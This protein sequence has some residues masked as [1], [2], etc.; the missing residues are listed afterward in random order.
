[1]P[2]IATEIEQSGAIKRGE[3][4]LSDGTMTD[5]YVD[6]YVFETR[7][8][9]LEAVRNGVIEHLE[10]WSFE[11]VAGPALGAV[12]IVTAVSLELG[13]SAVFVRKSTGLRGTQARIEG[14]V[15]KGM[16]AIIIE[17]VTM[18]GKTAIESAEILE[19]AG[20]IVEAIV[21]VVD[22]DE[23]AEERIRKAGY[24]FTSVLQV[25]TDL[26]ID[27]QKSDA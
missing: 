22:R 8:A 25:G 3:F 2:D 5:Y 15:D 13:V 27:Q 14:N 12:P 21:A 9:L 17:D 4:Q 23:G 18:T 1:M 20:A 16:R 10:D 7:P 19:A 11:I 6:K 26:A 24:D